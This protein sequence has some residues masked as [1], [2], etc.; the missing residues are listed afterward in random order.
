MKRLAIGFLAF[1]VFVL[2][3]GSG[4]DAQVTSNVLRRVML[5]RTGNWEGTAF[6]IDVD[7]LPFICMV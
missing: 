1:V 4:V 5:I 3:L 2:A 7:G 6:T